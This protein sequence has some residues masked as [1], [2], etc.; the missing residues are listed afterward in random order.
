MYSY[1]YPRPSLTVDGVV[2]GFEPQA[3]DLKVLL[4]L[5]KDP[6]FQSQWALPGGFVNVSDQGSQGESLDEA[7]VRELEE[8]TGIHVEYL[9]QLYT[10]GAPGRDPR[11]RVVSVAYFGLVRTSALR[12]GSDASAAHWISVP[13]TGQLAFD[14]D[15]I[16]FKALERLR[17]KIR[18]TPIGLNLLPKQFTLSELQGLYEVVLGHALDK[19]NFRKQVLNMGIL[20]PSGYTQGRTGAPAQLYAFNV[21]AYAKAVRNGFNFQI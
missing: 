7:V 5:R 14:H 20:S 16:L 18:W 21:K 4:V 15:D 2:F 1:E 12:A 6:P 11:G 9:E 19:R 8:E 10:F 13:D 17:T 3:K